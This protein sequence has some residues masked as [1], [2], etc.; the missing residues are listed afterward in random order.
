MDSRP[1]PRIA[2]LL[3]S[4]NR[5][6][7]TVA[8][9]EGL[10]NQVGFEGTLDVVLLDAGSTDGTA[11]AVEGRFPNAVV[12]RGNDR[13]F[14]S[15]GMHEAWK[16]ALAQGY[17]LYLWVNDDTLL[18]EDALVRVLN[19]HQKVSSGGASPALVVGSTRDPSTGEISYGG[20]VIPDPSAPLRFELLEPD[21]AEPRPA[22]TMNGNF[23]LVPQEVVDRIGIVDDVYF[24]GLGDFDYGL[25]ARRAGC[26]VW[27]APGTV[28]AC[29]PNRWSTQG[30]WA[31]LR[32][33]FGRRRTRFLPWYTFVR[34]WGGPRWPLSLVGLY[35]R[36]AQHALKA[37]ESTSP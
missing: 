32:Q 2:A 25:R 3:T 27:V 14:W 6:D 18:D 26:G 30:R 8:C 13:Q 7:L 1:P 9:I 23:V 35:A 16:H 29:S 34:R 28:G 21:T 5:R 4:H 10:A 17:D 37:D 20:R 15:R 11:E 36:H 33:V 12:L 22:A 24:H 19:T 31:R